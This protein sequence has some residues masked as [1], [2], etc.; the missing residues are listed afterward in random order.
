MTV[1]S[2]KEFIKRK[3]H[4]LGFSF[5]GVSK[6]EEL[7]D[8]AKRLEKWLSRGYNGE[9]R[10]MENYF[11]MRID[12]RKLVPNAKSV[13]SLLY[14]YHNPLKQKDKTSPKISQYAYGKDYHFIIKQ[15]LKELL[16][17]IREEIGHV[18]G[19]VFVDSA[20]V[21]ERDWAQRSGLGW[22]GKHTLLINPEIGSYFFLAEIISDLELEPDGP[23]KDHCGTCTRC[24][25]ACPT[26]AISNNGHIVD[27]SKC[28]SYLTIELKNAIP[29]T[30]KGQMDNWMFGCDV[31]QEV[32]PWNRFAKAHNEPF[33]NP[34]E[35]LLEMKK[36][37]WQ[38][39]TED[40]FRKVFK[41]SAVKRTKFQGLKRNIDFLIS[42]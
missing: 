24:I 7:T 26:E 31:C 32:C 30:F 13:I 28:I 22:Q 29:E 38:E 20:P 39:L 12:P 17:S 5:I 18:D 42:D 15:K 16:E 6:A 21:L 35:E 37:D 1:F 11:D 27:G 3:A 23:M 2:H 25:D 9:M 14:N 10:Y 34:H 4:D 33:F 36:N 40:V 19:R 41:K 8:S